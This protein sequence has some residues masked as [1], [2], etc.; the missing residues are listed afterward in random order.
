[1]QPRS[2]QRRARVATM[3][4]FATNGALPATLLARYAEVK[5]LLGLD[6]AVFGLLVVG[7]V[8]GAVCAF[9]LPGAILRRIGSRWTASVG[10][11]WITLALVLAATGVVLGNPWV[12][13]AGLVLSGFGD[14]VVDV[15]QNAHGLRVQEAYGRSL[16][17]SMHAGWSIGAAAGGLVGTAAASAGVP[18][19]VHVGAWGLL[20]TVV[21]TWSARAFLPDRPAGTDD[22]QGAGRVGWHAAWLLAPLALVALAGIT[23]EDI[24]NNWSAVLLATERDVPVAA[25]GIG[26]SVLLGAQFAGRLLG[27][28]FID[29]VGNRPALVTSLGLIAAGLLLAAWAPGLVLTLAGLALAGLGCAITVPLA[30]AGADALRGLRPHAGVT[31]IS[32]VMRAAS[33]GLSPAIGAI[34]MV[35]SLPLAMSLVSLLAILALATQTPRSR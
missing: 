16:L 27:D 20:C 26:L 15:A 12:F 11:A 17:S 9:H 7:F 14:A 23:V 22:E 4:A 28:R 21:M 10:T 33:I 32:W 6:S 34:A 29:L 24:G 5:D 25:A 30:F 19:V 31:W 1:M 2:P 18:L 35:A 8:L 3:I 13:L